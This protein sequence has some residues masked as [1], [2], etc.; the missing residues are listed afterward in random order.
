VSISLLPIR[1][2]H[3]K[4]DRPTGKRREDDT[5]DLLQCKLTGAQLLIKGLRLQLDDQDHEHAEVIARIDE[6]HGEV[7]R[8]LEDQ[9]ADLERRLDIRAF[10]EAAAAQ[11]QPITVITPVLPPHQAP[12][13]TA[14]PGRV[15]PSWAVADMPSEVDDDEIDENHPDYVPNPPYDLPEGDWR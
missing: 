1:I 8:G 15:P 2:S 10:A 7:V 14:N 13:A 4:R 6:R 9:I 11:T 3:F 5:V 12:M